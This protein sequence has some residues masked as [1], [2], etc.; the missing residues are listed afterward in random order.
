MEVGVVGIPLGDHCHSSNPIGI[1]R[2]VLTYLFLNAP[3]T[4]AFAITV[5]LLSRTDTLLAAVLVLNIDD[6][7]P[8][9][10]AAWHIPVCM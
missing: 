6:G 1:R 9:A 7:V 5:V 4:V 2:S 8:S 10:A 3:H